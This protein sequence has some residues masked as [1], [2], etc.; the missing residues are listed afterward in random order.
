[1]NFGFTPEQELLRDQVRRFLDDNCALPEVRRIMKSAQGYEQGHWQQ[2]AELGWLGLIIN[3]SDG[4]VGLN[5]VDLVVVLE[6]MGRSL[7]PGPYLSTLCFTAALIDITDS[8]TQKTLLPGIAEGKIKGSLALLDRPGD[9]HV[10][11][12]SLE[13]ITTGEGVFLSGSKPFVHDCGSADYFLVAYRQAQDFYLALLDANDPSLER[14]HSAT[15]DFTKRTGKLTFDNL[16]ISNAP[17]FKVSEHQIN[18]LFDIG[19]VGVAA[20]MIGAAEA[21]LAITTTYAQDR[22]QFGHAIGKYQGV[23]HR[24]AEMYVDIESFKSLVYYAAWTI[25]D[26]AEELSRSASLAKAFASDAFAAIG[27]DAVQ[28]HGAIGFTQEYDIQLYLKRSKW[29]RASFGNAD[30]HYEKIIEQKQNSQGI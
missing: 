5:W 26:S 30:F 28:L 12:I 15:M 27:I 29:S 19:A 4:G 25:T 16:D 18:R 24:L 13:A 22:I 6:E 7:Y 11:N 2:M 10:D 14:S 23:K 17:R 8:H 9:P 1:M 3:E 20:E 21:V